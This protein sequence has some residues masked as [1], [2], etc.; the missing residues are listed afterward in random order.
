MVWSIVSEHLLPEF[1]VPQTSQAE[2]IQNTQ[3]RSMLQWMQWLVHSQSFRWSLPCHVDVLQ[4]SGSQ[5]WHSC[6]QTPNHCS[7]EC[8]IKN[9][10]PTSPDIYTN[11]IPSVPFSIYHC[12]ISRWSWPLHLRRP[13]HRRPSPHCRS[14]M[15]GNGCLQGKQGSRF[16]HGRPSRPACLVVFPLNTYEYII[17]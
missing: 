14:T 15:V 6:L 4:Q 16:Q 7:F 10:L 11:T 17:I 3:R 13:K 1:G 9:T 5:G 12:S 8:Y 2:A